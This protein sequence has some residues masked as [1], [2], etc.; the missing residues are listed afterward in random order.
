MEQKHAKKKKSNKMLGSLFEYLN[1]IDDGKDDKDGDLDTPIMN[2]I[3][4]KQIKHQ[5]R[6]NVREAGEARAKQ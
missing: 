3:L 6:T 1:S 2:F 4:I 5:L